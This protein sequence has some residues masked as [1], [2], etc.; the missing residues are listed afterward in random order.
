MDTLPNGTAARTT[1]GGHRDHG[2]HKIRE[3]MGRKVD[4][5][6]ADATTWEFHGEFSADEWDAL[7]VDHLQ[8]L[9]TYAEGGPPRCEADWEDLG[10]DLSQSIDANR[11][12]DD[13]RY[14]PLDEEQKATLYAKARRWWWVWS[15]D[16][17]T[18]NISRLVVIDIPTGDARPIAQK[19]YPIPYHYRDAVLDELRK[20]LDGGHIEPTISEWG[21][22]ILV[23][24]KKDSTPDKIKLKIIC[25]FRMLNQVT[26]ADSAGLGDQDE[27]LDGFGGMQRYCGICDAAGG[28][29]Q[30]CIKPSGR[31]KTAFVLPTSMGGT[32]FQWRVAPYG[33]TRN[34]AGYSRGMMFALQ[35][36]SNIHLAP[37]GQSTGGCGSWIDD[38]S[39]HADS[40]EGFADLFER[41]LC[42]I[43]YAGMQLKASKSAFSCTNAWRYSATT[44]HWTAW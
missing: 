38:I 35:H 6:P 27:I 26:L 15:R 21:C 18:P 14:S 41:I 16:A 24:L 7:G 9:K 5:G 4:E 11:R 44:S 19:P 3:A 10:L 23:R 17:R 36:M 8:E 32:S 31:H 22:P 40:F 2:P 37:M 28:F 33:L 39:M 13:G 1:Q 34:P 20:L 43:A 29:Y 25:D 30:F 12:T 42:R